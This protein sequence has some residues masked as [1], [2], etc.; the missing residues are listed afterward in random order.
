VR[1]LRSGVG[2]VFRGLWKAI[3]A[4]F[5]ALRKLLSLIGR[6]FRP[7]WRRIAAMSR[8]KQV[9]LGLVIYLGVTVLLIA[10]LGSAGRNPEFQ[11]Q[12]EFALHPYVHLAIGP[13][14]LSINK[15]VVYV[16]LA[17][18][19]TTLAILFIA[20]RMDQRPNRTQVA[21]EWIY[22]FTRNT[23]TRTNMD[24]AMAKRWF[25]V[26]ATLFLFIWIS[27]LIGYI[28]LPFNTEHPL[29][30]FGLEVPAL[31]LYA[32]TA[33]IS[34]PLILTVF[35]W[36]AYHIE[37]I[38]RKGVVNY[39]K[40]WVPGGITGVAA[41]P[42]FV[43]EVISHLVRLISLS[44]RL[45]A[46]LLAGHLLLLF[47]GGGMAVLLGLAALGWVTLPV[48]VAFFLFEVGLI[49]TLQAFIFANLTA[50]YLGEA[51]EQGH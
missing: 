46:N 18:A 16:L 19:L 2:K 36:F 12:N 3:S 30:V 43:I 35:V 14:D 7:I 32:A 15:A 20:R 47:L 6:P 42:L 10:G 40:G 48:A 38:R 51:T 25:A 24:D 44:V 21:V 9:A 28:P 39:F 13:V 23:I 17:C 31:A 27:N 26:T 11:P 29:H 22:D 50:I 5:S 49:A 33:N 8:R 1:K 4:I 34:V 41:V 45:F 37:G